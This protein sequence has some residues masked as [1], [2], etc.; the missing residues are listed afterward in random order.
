MYKRQIEEGAS[1]DAESFAYDNMLNGIYQYDIADEK[2]TCLTEIDHIN[3]LRL[4]D[5]DGYYSSKDGYFVFDTESRQTRQ[6]P[7]D[8]DGKTQYGPLKKSGDFLYYALSEEKSDEVTYYRLKDDKSEEL[9]KLSTEKA[10]SIASICGQSV[11]VTYTNDNGKLC[12]GVIS[13]DELNKG[14]FEPKELRCFDDEE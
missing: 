3:D 13:L 1:D 7:I 8:A 4:L 14:V 2:T 12:L 5:G 9:M 11:Y 6:L 10:F